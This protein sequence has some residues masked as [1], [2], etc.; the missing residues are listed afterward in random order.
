MLFACSPALFMRDLSKQQEVA[1][2]NFRDE[3]NVII[4]FGSLRLQGALFDIGQ[5]LSIS[6]SAQVAAAI[7]AEAEGLDIYARELPDVLFGVVTIRQPDRAHALRRGWGVGWRLR[8]SC[9]RRIC[10]SLIVAGRV[11]ISAPAT[12]DQECQD[13]RQKEVSQHLAPLSFEDQEQLRPGQ[14]PEPKKPALLT[15]DET[16]TFVRGS[17]KECRN[18][19][20]AAP[21]TE[22]ASPFRLDSVLV[23]RPPPFMGHYPSTAVAGIAT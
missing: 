17:V 14:E 6:L 9:R 3:T 10:H 1:V 13:D 5:Q 12:R 11:C 18:I 8:R 15:S 16:P 22:D 19:A 4:R 21:A 7:E 20:L 2:V 23:H